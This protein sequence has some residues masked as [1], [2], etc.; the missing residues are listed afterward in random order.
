[1]AVGSAW[2][3]V[4]GAW[5]ASDNDA[6]VALPAAASAAIGDGS[7]GSPP[8]TLSTAAGAVA[9]SSWSEADGRAGGG[10]LGCCDGARDHRSTHPRR[11]SGVDPLP[12]GQLA[13]LRELQGSGSYR[14]YESYRVEGSQRLREMREARGAGG[15]GK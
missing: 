6:G 9:R 12:C 4:G 7:G 13:H 14:A 8:L 11:Q 2:P 5:V 3:A 1:M 15:R 10:A